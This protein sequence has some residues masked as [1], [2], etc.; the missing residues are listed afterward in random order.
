ME[1]ILKETIDNLGEVGDIVTVKTGYARNYLLPRK[2]AVTATDANRAIL[3]QQIATI[4]A[5]KERQR[6]ESEA[7]A[8]KLQAAD[9][10]IE[11]RSGDEGRLFGSV[12][13]ADIAEKL[14]EKGI[15]INRKSILMAEPI[16][17]LG[18]HV[19]TIRTG[20]Q[21]TADITVKVTPLRGQE[22]KITA[23][24]QPIDAEAVEETAPEA[25]EEQ[26]EA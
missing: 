21:I 11:H 9:I 15:E 22:E 6:R 1:L 20:Y 24:Q 10:V 5:D 18:E 23:R 14:A 4:E 12:T 2:L 13:T 7:L 19:V 16:K 17:S 25:V 8:K 3:E 26:E